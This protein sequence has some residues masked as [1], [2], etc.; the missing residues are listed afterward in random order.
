[1]TSLTSISTKSTNTNSTNLTITTPGNYQQ[2]LYETST[3]IP[4]IN[5]GN[6]PNFFLDSQVKE[7]K[8]NR[9]SNSNSLNN[10]HNKGIQI[11]LPDHENKMKQSEVELE[12]ERQGYTY[13][14]EMMVFINGEECKTWQ[15]FEDEI[16]E[17]IQSQEEKIQ[18]LEE[19]DRLAN[20]EE[21]AVEL[22]AAKQGYIFDKEENVFIK[23]NQRKTYRDFSR[24]IAITFHNK[25]I[26]N[27]KE[28]SDD[29][30]S[31][32]DMITNKPSF[33]YQ[34]LDNLNPR[35]FLEFDEFL[36]YLGNKG[37]QICIEGEFIIDSDGEIVQMNVVIEKFRESNKKFNEYLATYNLWYDS[38][39]QAIK[40]G[41]DSLS[42][43]QVD[44][45]LNQFFA[46]LV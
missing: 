4:I 26:K 42:A 44:S 43:E 9:N 34:K 19:L 30:L 16:N 37:W 14:E 3:Y 10:S 5:T 36:K 38:K 15:E 8:S 40:S 6:S 11:I 45:L 35:M 25:L 33:S 28:E 46:T 22:E 13:N 12:A 31:D 20:E 1:M 39:S 29:I 27:S 18:F 17:K 23:G 24:E 7:L 2:N 32:D 41:K 21:K